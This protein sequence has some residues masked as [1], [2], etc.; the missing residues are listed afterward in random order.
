MPRA[1][2]QINIKVSD[3]PAEPVSSWTL[4]VELEAAR[5][6]AGWAD[7]GGVWQIKELLRAQLKNEQ[8]REE[9]GGF[10]HLDMRPELGEE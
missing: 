4:A 3:F 5:Q 1:T 10:T 2:P 6:G 9:N 8:Q 7:C